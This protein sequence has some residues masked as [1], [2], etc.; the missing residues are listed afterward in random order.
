VS[1]SPPW[2]SPSPG[3]PRSGPACAWSTSSRPRSKPAKPSCGRWA[4]TIRMSRSCAPCPV[5]AGCWG[6]RSPPRSATSAGSPAP[7]ASPK[8][9]G[10][11]PRVYQ[12]GP[13]DRRGALTKSGPK[14]L[15]WALIEA[16]ATAA[17][18]PQY[19]ERYEHTKR[20]LG[21]QRGSKIARVLARPRARQRDLAHAHAPGAVP[22]GRPHIRS[23][24][25][26]TLYDLGRRCLPPNRVL[27]S[28]EADRDM[29]RAIPL[30]TR[31]PPARTL[32]SGVLS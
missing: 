12:S 29:R 1:C 21:K 19:R 9:T 23:G 16:A 2:R 13:V 8:Y 7:S 24:R 27:P 32:T 22:S 4:P 3:P 26:T 6:T 18:N 20:R 30:P 28:E 11:C 5:S 17:R 25:L 15:R 14:Y 31:S 10:L